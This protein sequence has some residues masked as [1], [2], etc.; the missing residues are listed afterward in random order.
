MQLIEFSD[1]NA[2]SAYVRLLYEFSCQVTTTL[3][4]V[5]QKFVVVGNIFDDSTALPRELA[6]CL[7]TVSI[8]PDIA[9]KAIGQAVC[10]WMLLPFD[11]A[12]C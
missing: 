5:P 12:G 6:L 11:V 9:G 3:L 4:T 10:I 2:Q 7:R 8:I 1:Q